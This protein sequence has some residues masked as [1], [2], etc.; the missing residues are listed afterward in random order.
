MDKDLGMAN[1]VGGLRIATRVNGYNDGLRS[2][3]SADLPDEFRVGESGRVD[4]DLVRSRFKDSRS[5]VRCADASAYSKW[6]KE[7]LRSAAD[8]VKQSCASLMRGGDVEQDNF[9][10]SLL[11]VACCQSGWISRI[12][13]VDELD[14][15]DYAAIADVEAGDDA[16]SEH[17]LFL[18]SRYI[19]FDQVA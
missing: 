8:G 14:A 17:G 19:A 1:G 11:R 9:V 16:A 18:S 5:I 10:G 2:K 7:R 3:T 6:D 13:E 12:D 4:A 15:F